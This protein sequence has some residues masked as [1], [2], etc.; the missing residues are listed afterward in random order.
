MADTVN[1][2]GIAIEAQ[3]ILG[4]S[5]N[6]A[7]AGWSGAERGWRWT[8]F[9]SVLADVLFVCLNAVVVFF[10]RFVPTSWPRG[11]L[12]SL[13]RGL[14]LGPYAGFLLL[15]VALIVL[16]CQSQDLY[17]TLR[18]RS[19]LQEGV[20]V[21]KAVA[22]ATLLLTAFVY[23]SG[24][25]TVSRL[26]IGFSGVLNIVTLAS[27]R[28]WRLEIVKQRVAT[29]RAARNVLIVGAG[30]IGH[31]LAQHLEENKQLGY[32]VRGFLDQNH[33]G[34]R[35]V[36]GNISDLS[37][38]ALAYFVDEVF[39]TIPSERSVVEYV[40][41]EA[42]QQRLNVK[43]VPDLFDGLGWHAPIRYLGD[44]PVMELHGEPIPAFGLLV[45]RMIDIAS[46]AAGL[47]AL[48]PVL[49]AIALAIKFDSPGPALYR[50]WRMGRKGRKFLCC[51]FRTMVANA[52]QIK[53]S[54]RHL[55]ERDGPFFKITNDPRLIRIGRFLRRHSLDELPQLWNVLKGDM[56]LVGPR[57]HPLDDY[58]QYNLEH[59]RRLD[60]KPGLTGLWQVTARRDPSFERNM[61]L[62][63][64]YIENWNLWLDL[65]ILARTLPVV[66][67]GDGQ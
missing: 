24:V 51:K 45:K 52:D 17:R 10:L 6:G 39:V 14:P 35:R 26:V 56:S 63:L 31:A 50:S 9:G 67:G 29:G 53:D 8:Q 54:L 59:L 37:K 13:P 15:Y 21:I 19:A 38:V 25:W 44:F 48:A 12:S 61:A 41:L 32:V 27:W 2:N 43:V 28:L 22:L 40:A 49:A 23:L 64:E 62:D 20:A 11:P 57:P 7:K 16:S 36:L 34:N 60:V 46:S 18:T 3:P 4:A 33:N 1:T 5:R 58:E 65:K 30:R 47:L 55:N 42:R 66:L